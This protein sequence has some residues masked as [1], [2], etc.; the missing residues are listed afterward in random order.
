MQFASEGL[1][2]V[3][4][5]SSVRARE[6]VSS[7]PRRSKATAWPTAPLNLMPV[8]QFGENYADK[9][10]KN[11]QLLITGGGGPPNGAFLKNITSNLVTRARPMA[12]KISAST[13]A[14]KKVTHGNSGA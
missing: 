7:T 11:S 12:V 3:W 2:E 5:G 13:K 8:S 9:N 10:D 4:E 1:W 6:A 14:L